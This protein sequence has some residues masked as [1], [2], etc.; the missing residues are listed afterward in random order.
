MSPVLVL[1][2]VLAAGCTTATGQ[3]AAGGVETIGN[4][5]YQPPAGFAA[6]EQASE[7][8][9]MTVWS[10]G[11]DEPAWIV[12]TAT[13]H[14]SSA[15]ALLSNFEQRW[16]PRNYLSAIPHER[17]NATDIRPVTVGGSRWVARNATAVSDDGTV[18][19]VAAYGTVDDS[20]IYT[21]AI[22]AA[23]D[24][25]GLHYPAFLESLRNTTVSQD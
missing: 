5:E 17:W 6:V 9:R 19:T 2:A 18:Q 24:R 12:M 14:P 7:S 15:G 13:G 16:D 20:Y 10:A 3:A 1:L 4:L 21:V 25:F 23:Q 22:V 8:A 11:A